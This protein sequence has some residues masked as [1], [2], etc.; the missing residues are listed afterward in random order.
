[1]N[2]IPLAAIRA[3]LPASPHIHFNAAGASPSDSSVVGRI[4]DH[5]HLEASIGGYAA[6]TDPD[7]RAKTAAVYKSTAS[8]INSEC[9]TAIALHDSSTTSFNN[10]IYSVPMTKNSVII[11]ASSAEYASNAIS[12]LNHSRNSGSLAPI[13]LPTGGV[14]LDLLSQ[15]LTNPLHHVAA[16][17][18]TH[19]PTNG[20]LVTDAAAVGA[21]LSSQPTPPLYLL[22][23]CQT[24]GQRPIDVRSFQ[25]DAAAG[26]SRKWLRGPRGVGFLYVKPASHERFLPPPNPD[27]LWSTWQP[28]LQSFSTTETARRFEL[29]E[30]SVANKLGFGRAVD[31][32]LEIGVENIQQRVVELATITR[33]RITDE[34]GLEC[35]DSIDTNVNERS[36]I[37]SFDVTSIGVAAQ[38]VEQLRKMDISVSTSGRTSTLHDAT[39]RNLP[40][41]MVRF[42]P[43]YFNTTDEID[44]VVA[45]LKVIKRKE[46]NM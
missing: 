30:G 12:I 24:V 10:A 26:T 20:G 31:L 7:T 27:L 39:L 21:L 41:T 3:G 6:A 29:W 4:T 18:L 14:D 40:E 5:L 37:C 33:Q 43:H 42:S 13:F 15:H 16:V 34:I 1:M 22:D 35:M 11:S 2:R 28:D 8:L 45:A 23:I 17:V 46:L 19:A 25:C 32:A 36:G 38:V 9:P 44:R